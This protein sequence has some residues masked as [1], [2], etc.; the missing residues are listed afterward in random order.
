MGNINNSLS[1]IIPAYNESQ[2]IMPT[3]ENVEKALVGLGLEYEVIVI[4]DGS[5]DGTGNIVEENLRKYPKVRLI[6]NIENRGIGY[7]YKRGVNSAT[8]KY[9]CLIEGDNVWKDKT[10]RMLFSH[11]GEADVILGHWRTMWK[12]RPLMR[13]IISRS[14]AYL[15]NFLMRQ[16]I[17]SYGFQIQKTKTVQNMEIKSNGY[18]LFQEIILR[19][20]SGGK[21]YIE[22]EIDCIERK[23]GETKFFTLRNISEIVKMYL[24]LYTQKELKGTHRLFSRK[25]LS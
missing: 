15:L 24:Y 23:I 2:N 4:D 25:P 18:V 8:M 3:L 16:N 22:L 14:G 7:S 11:I 21:P 5:V 12:T 6:K 9:V 17:K 19:S 10:M 20:L 1:V 13:T